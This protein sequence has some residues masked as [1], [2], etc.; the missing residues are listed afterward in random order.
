MVRAAPKIKM[1]LTQCTIPT[2][3]TKRN[4]SAE[5][6]CFVCYNCAS[7]QAHFLEQRRA[8][9]KVLE[10]CATK[11][12]TG[13]SHSSQHPQTKNKQSQTKCSVFLMCSCPNQTILVFLSVPS[14][15]MGDRYLR[16][17]N[18]TEREY[19]RAYLAPGRER[20]RAKEPS[21]HGR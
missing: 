21:G 7:G 6:H 11:K 12:C 3:K 5:N 13:Y 16:A 15:G 1:L 2:L 4:C 14:M 18:A 10:K 9:K 8:E 20:H 17:N 19:N